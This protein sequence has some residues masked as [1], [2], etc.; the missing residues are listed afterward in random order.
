MK[1]PRNRTQD[2]ID[3][4]ETRE[5]KE[6][7]DEVIERDGPERA[8][9]LIEV[10]ESLIENGDVKE[11]LEAYQTAIILDPGKNDVVKA[12]EGY[13]LLLTHQLPQESKIEVLKALTIAVQRVTERASAS[14]N[15]HICWQATLDGFAENV[16]SACERAVELDPDH[17]SPL[18]RWGSRRW[19]QRRSPC[20]A[21]RSALQVSD[22]E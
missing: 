12:V 2:D 15:N 22:L 6:A 1:M 8:H 10:A 9:Y 11:G 19:A 13:Q 18:P 3:P 4:L 16:I 17:R 20:R 14:T 7:L 5:W 21:P